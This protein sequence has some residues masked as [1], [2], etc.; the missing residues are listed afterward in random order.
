MRFKIKFR[1]EDESFWQWFK[2][3]ELALLNSI[4]STVN[5]AYESVRVG[6][7]VLLLRYYFRHVHDC[8]T[9][10]HTGD[11]LTMISSCG[12]EEVTVGETMQLT[13]VIKGLDGF[14][15]PMRLMM[16]VKELNFNPKH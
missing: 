7:D 9:F 10:H 5:Y 11:A 13:M 3:A 6:A 4:P 15:T 1:V 14:H 2:Q 12:N 16:G 8:L